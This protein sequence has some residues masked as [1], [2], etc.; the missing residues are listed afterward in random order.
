MSRSRSAACRARTESPCLDDNAKR[1]LGVHIGVYPPRRV[2][3]Y[4]DFGSVARKRQEKPLTLSK[5]KGNRR[6]GC[7]F[8]TRMARIARMGD[9]HADGGWARGWG[10][11]TRMARIARMGTKGQL[12]SPVGTTDYSVGV[13]P[14]VYGYIINNASPVRGQWLK[15][16]F[17]NRG[18]STLSLA[19]ARNPYPVVV[20]SMG[21]GFTI[22]FTYGA[23]CAII[24]KTPALV[25]SPKGANSA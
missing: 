1:F 20:A 14:Y 9:G 15:Y 16:A 10:F 11:R 18:R 22:G 24:K 6:R 4:E 21:L 19:L 3:S 7:F 23:G 8:R 13:Y 2:Q 25:L 5:L 17:R 12:A